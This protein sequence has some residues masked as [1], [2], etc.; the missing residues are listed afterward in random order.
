VN[1]GLPGLAVIIDCVVNITGK[2]LCCSS[3][4]VRTVRKE[5]QYV[6]LSG[7]GGDRRLHPKQAT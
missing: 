2:A 3:I 1:V 6:H 4:P 7:S 5:S